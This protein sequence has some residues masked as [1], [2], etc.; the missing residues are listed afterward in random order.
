M[1][2]K[3]D[4]ERRDRSRQRQKQGKT[5]TGRRSGFGI[6]DLRKIDGDVDFFKPKKQTYVIDFVP[7]LIT[8]NILDNLRDPDG[9]KIDVREGDEEYKLEVP[10]HSRIGTEGKT[11]F[12][13]LLAFG[14]PCFICEQKVGLTWPEDKIA[15]KAHSPQWRN[16]YNLRVVEP[17]GSE[18]KVLLWDVAYKTFES[19]MIDELREVENDE[20]IEI[21]VGGVEDDIRSVRFRGIE[22]TIPGE[23]DKP[24][25]FVGFKSFKFP[26]R[27][28]E[29]DK[30]LL[31][32]AYPL[33][34]MLIIHDYDYVKNLYLG[35]DTGDE[36]EGKTAKKEE[37]GSEDTEKDDVVPSDEESGDDKGWDDLKDMDHDEMMALIKREGIQQEMRGAKRKSKKD[38]QKM[39]KKHRKKMLEGAEEP[40]EEN[41]DDDAEG[42][43]PKKGDKGH[44]PSGYT[45]LGEKG[46]VLLVPADEVDDLG[47]NNDTHKECDK[48]E[49]WQECAK[50][51]Q[52]LDAA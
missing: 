48:C 13:N 29:L 12:C 31:D 35:Y 20:D 46:I 2:R 36:D 49:V 4:K 38:L 37:T 3:R 50:A 28:E 19:E 17:T 11:A 10:V 40:K 27:D 8:T 34:T 22:K 15:I 30:D 52:Q 51:E 45:V 9:N 41:G 33:D 43:T 42:K 7:F 5:V 6:L 32:D 26:E 39:L 18:D 25:S 16:M 1:S 14:L 44:C 23:G 21:F 24:I 47:K